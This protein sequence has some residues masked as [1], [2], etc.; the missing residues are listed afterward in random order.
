MPY[1]NLAFYAAG[2]HAAVQA[3][4]P[5][6]AWLQQAAA[7]EPDRACRQRTLMGCLGQRQG[8]LGAVGR[9]PSWAAQLQRRDA[10]AIPEPGTAECDQPTAAVG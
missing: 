8:D 4:Q 6:N 1:S 7:W 10:L 9:A 5:L 2:A 3:R